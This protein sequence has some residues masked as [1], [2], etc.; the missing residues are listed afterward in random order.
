MDLFFVPKIISL[1]TTK[2]KQKYEELA[3]FLLTGRQTLLCQKRKGA[4]RIS[5]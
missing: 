2:E 5:T 1:G 4:C 3:N